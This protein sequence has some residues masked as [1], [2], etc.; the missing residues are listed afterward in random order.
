MNVKGSSTII[1][2]L[3]YLIILS[4]FDPF[5]FFKKSDP[6]EVCT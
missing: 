1:S 4:Y 3:T 2:K 6:Y 5:D